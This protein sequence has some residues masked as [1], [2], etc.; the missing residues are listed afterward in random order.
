MNRRDTRIHMKKTVSFYGLLLRWMGKYTL[1][2]SVFA[3]VPAL[4][5]QAEDSGTSTD[6]WIMA[7]S[8]FVRPGLSLKPI[9]TSELGTLSVS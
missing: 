7:G 3:L 5:A 8:D 1:A 6:F 4:W 2:V 9:T